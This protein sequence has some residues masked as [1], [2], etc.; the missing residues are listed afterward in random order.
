MLKAIAL[1]LTLN[2]CLMF[3]IVGYVKGFSSCYL[4]SDLNPLNVHKWNDERR[5]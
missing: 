3:G 1:L 2:L 5:K 4:T